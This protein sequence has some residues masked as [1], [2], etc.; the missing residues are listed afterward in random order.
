M[1]YLAGA[2]AH[3][4][5]RYVFFHIFAPLMRNRTNIFRITTA[6]IITL[7]L[8]SCSKESIHGDGFH[9]GPETGKDQSIRVENKEQRN[10]LLLYSAGHNSISSYLEEDIQDL[11]QGWIPESRRNSNVLLIYSHPLA[12]DKPYYT[13]VSPT[14]TRLSTDTN[15]DLIKDTLIVYPENTRSATAE[16]LHEV[17]DYV[18]NTFPAKS[19]GMIFSSHATG[20]LPAGYYSKPE[21]YLFPGEKKAMYR[22]GKRIRSSVPV[23]YHEPE[24]DP[25]LPAVKSIGQDLIKTSGTSMSYE[26]ELD[27]FAEAIPM[28]LDYI[29][30]DACLMGGV[31]VAYELK[32]KCR[33]IGFS[34]TEVLAE[35]FDYKTLT[36][37]LLGTETPDPKA[38]C[39]DY[40][41]Q[42]DIQ[43]GIYRSATISMIDCSRMAHLA[44]T[45]KVLFEK[46]RKQIK[47]L[48]PRDVQKY[49]RYDYH[50]FYDLVDIV[51]KAGA[52]LEELA[53][54]EEALDE[55]VAYKAST[56]EF[57]GSFTID[58]Y[59]GFSMYLPCNGSPELDKYYKTLQWNKDTGLVE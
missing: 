14:L 15:G 31:E 30:F 44:E 2:P 35:G 59:S 23:P 39:R 10:V 54:L 12:K 6:I 29:L 58:T 18:Q 45:C 57:M 9:R 53:Q 34:Q 42:Y 36:S 4:L 5:Q 11:Q 40:F 13:P 48:K 8:A 28:K 26:I 16:Q 41:M 20:Y 17:L 56:P 21:D 22:G 46:Y 49:Y 3:I 55:C 43:S 33:H 7:S 1:P 38:V 24:H 51:A 25:S 37:H 52:T 32:D 27:D 50:W 47:D 19:Y